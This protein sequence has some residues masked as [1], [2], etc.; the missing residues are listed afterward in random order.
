M[1]SNA[2]GAGST[3]FSSAVCCVS[4]PMGKKSVIL[5][6]LLATN[7]PGLT[8][9]SS[10][11][12]SLVRGPN[13]LD[14]YHSFS[15][16]RGGNAK[17]THFDKHL[18]MFVKYWTPGRVK[19]RLAAGLRPQTAA[20]LYRCFV[21]T[22][23]KRFASIGANRTV[24]YWPPSHRPEIERAV[25][26]AWQFNVQVDG[27][28]GRRMRC[29]FEQH[30]AQNGRRPTSSI[31]IGS[32][33]PTIPEVIVEQAF[34]KLH[35]V[36]VVLGPTHDGGYYLV[37]VRGVLPPIFDGIAWSTS[38]VWRQTAERLTAAAIPF[39]TLP[40]WYDVDSIDDLCQLRDELTGEYLHESCYDE[41]RSMVGALD[42][43]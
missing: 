23:A 9:I 31:L 26:D 35:D 25:G 17:M 42:I 38:D 5:S 4:L 22:L 10:G 19:T 18:A 20:Q 11:S 21:T 37:G 30:Q 24:V 27:D 39:A 3:K 16:S 6:Q 13:S 34:A 8:K 33:S 28:L 41:L 43:S 40:T 1:A 12:S 14:F 36:P 2:F 32:D 7:G 15:S 29:H